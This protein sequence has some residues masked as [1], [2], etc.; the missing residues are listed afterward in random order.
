MGNTQHYTIM[1]S[2]AALRFNSLHPDSH[3]DFQNI[4]QTAKRRK[5]SSDEE[6]P[7]HSDEVNNMIKNKLLTK[8]RE[9]DE[10]AGEEENILEQELD[11]GSDS[12]GLLHHADGGMNV[13][14][15][16]D[17]SRTVIHQE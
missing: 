15:N 1:K 9:E 13:L 8:S 6:S 16:T 2:K 11:R 12:S 17:H 14:L 3:K 4:L 7:D 5:E 10:E